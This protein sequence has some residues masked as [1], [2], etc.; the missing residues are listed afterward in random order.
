MMVMVNPMLKI[1]CG[2]DINIMFL[3]LCRMVMRL[4][5]MMMKTMMVMV[6]LMNLMMMKLTLMKL[7]MMKLR[8]EARCASSSAFPHIPINTPQLK[9]NQILFYLI[10][11]I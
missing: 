2:V 7:T 10:Y 11:Y 4:K 6:T 8:G 3:I 9:C 5:L 1:D